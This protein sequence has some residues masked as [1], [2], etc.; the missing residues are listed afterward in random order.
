LKQTILIR[1]YGSH[2]MGMGH[3]YRIRNLVKVISTSIAVDITLLTQGFDESKNLYLSIGVEHLYEMPSGISEVH[4]IEFIEKNLA[5]SYD[6]LINDQLQTSE[7]LA[8]F[9]VKKAR[10]TLSIDDTGI[11]AHLFNRLINVL[12]PNE[13]VLNNEINS[14]DYLILHNQ[15]KIKNNY[16]SANEVSKIFINQGAADTWG[17]IP[18]IIK[19]LEHLSNKFIL[20]VLLG[21]A[22]KHY[23]ELADALSETKHRIELYNFTDDVLSLAKDCQLAILGAGNTMFEVLSIGVPVVACTREEKELI[24]I[25]RLIDEKLVYGELSLFNNYSLVGSTEILIDNYN[26]RNRLFD[27]N[28]KTFSYKG[29]ELIVKYVKG[30]L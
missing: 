23:R 10:R 27:L 17:T 20:K 18:D 29:L 26:E 2:L 6:L 8:D 14:F 28:R 11:G 30:M 25:K 5:A 1:A 12:Y 15:D 24:T 4:E 16:H 3:L 9:F 7:I 21:P 13:V 19:D 22:F